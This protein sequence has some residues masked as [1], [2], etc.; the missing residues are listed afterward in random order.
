M[1]SFLSPIT[2]EAV[3]CLLVQKCQRC[4]FRELYSQEAIWPISILPTVSFSGCTSTVVVIEMTAGLVKDVCY[5]SLRTV[6]SSPFSLDFHY[7]EVVSQGWLSL[8]LLETCSVCPRLAVLL[9][10]KEAHLWIWG[11]FCF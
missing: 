8:C 3:S 9:L 5:P 1:F 7:L 2:V 4:H 6:L 10:S 11:N